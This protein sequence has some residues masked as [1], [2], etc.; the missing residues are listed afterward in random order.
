MISS[1]R[2]DWQGR[3][4]DDFTFENVRLHAWK[5]LA[6]LQANQLANKLLIIGYDARFLAAKFAE[7]IVKVMAEGRVN[8]FLTESDTPLPV[9]SWS[10]ADKKAGAAVMVTGSNQPAEYCG[11]KFILGGKAETRK[12]YVSLERFAPRAR[13]LAYVQ[14]LVDVSLFKSVKFK[15][16]I[17]PMHGST[18]EYLSFLYQ[19]LGGRVEA[20][21]DFRDVLFGGRAPEPAE[22]NLS[23]LKTKMAESRTDLGLALNG[24][25]TSF[26]L[27]DRGGYFRSAAGLDAIIESLRLIENRLKK[28]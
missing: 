24:D 26:A 20:V 18:R 3:I 2:Q 21:N 15:I 1:D 4:S 14:T 22:T 9:V 11:I 17:D 6:Y 12:E 23:D 19:G 7:A 28:R 10:L 8:C 25:G 13:Y 16:V 5:I 27:I